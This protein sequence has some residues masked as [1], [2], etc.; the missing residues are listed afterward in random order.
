MDLINHIPFGLREEDQ[1]YADVADVPKGRLCGCVCP[2]CHLPLIARQGK[3]NRWH[4]AH[5][6]RKVGDIAQSCQYS[7]FVSVRAMA[8]Q[9]IEPGFRL[10]KPGYTG[11]I[12]E[13]RHGKL[14]S[15]SF[16]V[17]DP[18]TITLGTVR[19][20]CLF[21]QTVVD[22][23]TEVNGY[24]LVIYFSHPERRVPVSLEKPDNKR[25]GVLGIDLTGMEAL[26]LTKNAAS[27]RFDEVIKTFI[28]GDEH[29]KKW[30]YYPDKPSVRAGA[31]ARLEKKIANWKPPLKQVKI[32]NNPCAHSERD[33]E[34]RYECQMCKTKWSAFKYEKAVCPGCRCS[35][36][37]YSRP[38]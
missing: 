21:E 19:K 12:S 17:T 31:R 22:I 33:R 15:E 2:S 25:C 34:C 32:I 8:R 18:G 16:C 36:H 10:F 26:F 35:A 7:F 24:P 6:G 38:I 5:A 23:C 37:L 9:I 28:E 3:V 1:M 14:F 11:Q 13:R 29:S 27:D 30:I 4:F 20:E